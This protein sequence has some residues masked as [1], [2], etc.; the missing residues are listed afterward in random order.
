MFEK[1]I[2]RLGIKEY[3]FF[4][5]A[6]SQENAPKIYQNAD[7]YITITY[8]DNCPSAVMEAISCGLPVLYSSS[9]GVPEIVGNKAGIGLNVPYDW[10]KIHIPEINNIVIGLFKIM[11]NRQK[12]SE[13]A[14][15]RA[16]NLFDIKIGLKT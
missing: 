14:R 4:L 8:Q 6:Y 3:V 5:G 13:S 9:G 12:F 2:E 10:E 7:A 11:E 1:E 16:I 15:E